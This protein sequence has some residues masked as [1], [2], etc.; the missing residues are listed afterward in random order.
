MDATFS[1]L[2][3]AFIIVKDQVA[4][5]KSVEKDKLFKENE[6]VDDSNNI[7]IKSK[8]NDLIKISNYLSEKNIEKHNILKSFC[9][10]LATYHLKLKKLILQLYFQNT[11]F[12]NKRKSFNSKFLE[13]AY[14]IKG[15]ENINEWT[16]KYGISN[17]KFS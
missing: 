4:C 1:N 13:E 16:I 15:I 17:I 3:S 14:I 8:T 10:M 9:R 6:F 7:N 12:S 2:S 11:G 5:F